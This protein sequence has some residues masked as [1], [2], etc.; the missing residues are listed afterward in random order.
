MNSLRQ[1]RTILREVVI[2]TALVGCLNMQGCAS[3]AGTLALG[4]GIGAVGA[5]AGL[6]CAIGCQ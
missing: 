2:V 5:I 6:A 4:A 1:H 3:T